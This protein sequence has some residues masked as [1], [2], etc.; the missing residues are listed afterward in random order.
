MEA[1]QAG[2]LFV[3]AQ[4]RPDTGIPVG[5]N[6]HADA[7]AA[8]EDPPGKPARRDGLR[9]GAGEVGVIHGLRA[10]RAGVRYGDVPLDQDR[11]D[12]FLQVVTGVVGA[13][14]DG[15]HVHG[16]NFRRTITALAPPN[17]KVLDRAVRISCRRALFGT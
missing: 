6:G 5:G 4:G 14:N 9:H 8:D 3:Q 2:R 10:V 1:A 13:E 15:L 7:G 16:A 17:P 11:L 12:G